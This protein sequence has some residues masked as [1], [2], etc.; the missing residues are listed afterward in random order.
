MTS[1]DA[2]AETAADILSPAFPDADEVT[3]SA[4]V[5]EVLQDLAARMQDVR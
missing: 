4:L 5:E 1:Y 2:L 3:F